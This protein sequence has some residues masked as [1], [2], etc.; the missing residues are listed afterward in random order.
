MMK[1]EPRLRT[2][3]R[4]G[5]PKNFSKNGS[6][7]WAPSCTRVVL[8]LT[9]AGFSVLASPTHTG[10]G[11]AGAPTS[12]RSLHNGVGGLALK[13]NLGATVTSASAAISTAAAHRRT[14]RLAL[15]ERSFL[16]IPQRVMPGARSLRAVPRRRGGGSRRTPAPWRYGRRPG[17]APW[18]AGDEPP[19][20]GGGAGRPV[21]A[22]RWRPPPDRRRAG[23]R[24]ARSGTAARRGRGAPPLR[25]RRGPPAGRRPRRTRHPARRETPA[26]AAPG[27][28]LLRIG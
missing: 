27:G 20:P 6:P 17:R 11:A 7:G 16:V 23:S 21:A 8:T 28:R 15:I 26:P 3:R 5:V 18:P 25:A 9:T 14:D 10:G 12:G 19:P 24:P 1:P 2:A 22:A 13:P 4:G